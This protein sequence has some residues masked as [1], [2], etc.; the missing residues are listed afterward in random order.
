MA[1]PAVPKEQTPRFEIDIGD[2]DPDHPTRFWKSCWVI[3][4]S[5]ALVLF[6]LKSYGARNVP[7]TGGALLLTNHQS[8]LDPVMFGVNLPRQLSYL[9][10]SE[11]FRNPFFR[12]LIVNLHAFPVRQGKGDKA[13]IEE[14]IRRLREGHLLNLYPEG[15]RSEDGEIGPIQ[16][17]VAVVLKRANVPIVPAVI[18][19]SFQ[20]WPKGKPVFRPH[21]IRV[22]YGKP[23][24]LEGLKGDQV[25]ALI[26]RTLR[27]ML[28][29]LRAGRI[30]PYLSGSD[31]T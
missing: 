15:S 21:S 16:R 8:Y 17:G 2:V 9:A 20:A 1:E 14:T 11:L 22:L 18:D 25:V 6:D 4:R 24:L 3:A 29:D 27:T 10:K 7:R 13:A 26:D 28:A 30:E 5:A 12:W 23:M 19:G 31:R